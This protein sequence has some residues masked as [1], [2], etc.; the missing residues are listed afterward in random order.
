[1]KSIVVSRRSRRGVM[2]GVALTAAGISLAP[3]RV[4]KTADSIAGERGF[5]PLQSAGVLA[6]GPNNI[7]F[8]GDIAG[9]AV[10]AFA[11]REKDLTP[12]TDVEL[13][14]FHNFEGRDL[15]RGVD[16]KLAALFGTTYDK[17]VV[18]DMVV[19]QPSQQI[20]LS[21]E[22]GREATN[23]SISFHLVSCPAVFT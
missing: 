15:I 7:L 10:H 17:I 2:R 21:V 23:R 9:A 8:I 12:Q 4:F 3:C 5:G 11:L 14:N 20:F 22:R 19:H 6:F 1:M 13:G 18:N 16:H